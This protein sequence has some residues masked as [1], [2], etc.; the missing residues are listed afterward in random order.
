[1]TLLEKIETELEKA[2]QGKANELKK[3]VDDLVKR[4][5]NYQL[6]VS[7]YEDASEAVN[8]QIEKLIKENEELKAKLNA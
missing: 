7:Q 6:C 3:A 8:A 4:F 2:I 5:K 1:M